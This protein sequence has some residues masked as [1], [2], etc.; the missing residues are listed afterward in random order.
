LIVID[1]G[2]I[3]AK[4]AFQREIDRAIRLVKFLV[5]YNVVI[6]GLQKPGVFSKAEVKR[7]REIKEQDEECAG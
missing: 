3:P 7:W 1:L 4:H 5:G 6:P 2:E